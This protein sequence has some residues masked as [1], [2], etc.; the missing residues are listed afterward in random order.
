MEMYGNDVL[1]QYNIPTS[2]ELDGIPDS[3]VDDEEDMEINLEDTDDE[4]DEARE[5]MEVDEEV[6]I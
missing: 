5:E 3:D 6:E 2:E 1:A 4:E